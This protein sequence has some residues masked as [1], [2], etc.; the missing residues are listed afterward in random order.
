M[1]CRS[2]LLPLCL[3]FISIILNCNQTND[4]NNKNSDNSNNQMLARL[5]AQNTQ[6]IG[7]KRD[8]SG[9]LDRDAN[10]E[11]FFQTNKGKEYRLK[12]ANKLLLETTSKTI[13]LPEETITC[14][15]SGSVKVTTSS[16]L[17]I[18]TSTDRFNKTAEISNEKITITFDNCSNDEKMTTKSGTITHT[19]STKSKLTISTTNNKL[20]ETRTEGAETINGTKTISRNTP[21]GVKDTTVKIQ[22]TFNNIKIVNS[23]TVD[24]T[25]N[26][27][28]S[29]TPVSISGNIT[30][31]V[32]HST[33]S[34]E[35]T[36][37]I[38]KTINKT[39]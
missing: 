12:F 29:I 15:I 19:Q 4:S 17:T 35:K 23:Y 9:G 36:T 22:N 1:L 7:T 31:Q 8:E 21:R 13:S 16:D 32:T 33:P 18:L 14:T 27:L 39:F 30:G 2:N 10:F 37:Q 5:L 25:S 24:S 28:T 34:G 6:N 20:T 11:D 26:T 38:N 3:L